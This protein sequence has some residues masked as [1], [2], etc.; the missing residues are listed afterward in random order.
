VKCG[1]DVTKEEAE[2]QRIAYEL[3][4]SRIVRIPRVYAFITDERGRGYLVI[5][6]IEG[7]IA[8]PLEESDVVPKI[9]GVLDYFATTSLHP[10]FVEDLPEGFSSRN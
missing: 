7:R 5:E 4:D 1:P 8:E 6:F 10:V 9:A 3:V 2:K